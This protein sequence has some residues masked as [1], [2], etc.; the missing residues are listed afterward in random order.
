MRI[1][2]AAVV[3]ICLP[4]VSNPQGPM[5]SNRGTAVLVR[6]NGEWLIAALRVYPDA[7]SQKATDGF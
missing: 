2:I 7:A 1:A 5:K 4:T 6:Q 3:L